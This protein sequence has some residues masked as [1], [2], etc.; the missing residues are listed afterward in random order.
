VPSWALHNQSN[1]HLSTSFWFLWCVNIM[2]ILR[3][4]LIF[5]RDRKLLLSSLCLKMSLT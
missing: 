1:T 4:W 3:P 2:A 5:L